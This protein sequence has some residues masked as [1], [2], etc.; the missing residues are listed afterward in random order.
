[1]SIRLP[2]EGKVIEVVNGSLKIPNEPIVAYIEG[3]GIGREVIPAA[4]KVVDKAV[5]TAYKGKRRIVWWKLL[6]GKEALQKVGKLLPEETVKGIAEVKVALKGPMETP[7]GTGHRSINVALRKMFDLYANIRPIKYYGVPTVYP[8]ADK[9][10]LIIFRENTEDVYAG[11]EWEAYSREAQKLREFLKNEFGIE[12]REDSGITL[13]PISK[14]ATQ[15]IVRKA[16]KWAIEKG[17]KRVTIMHKGNVMKFTEGAFR[18]WA[19]E[20]AEKEFS[21]YV[22]IGKPEE[23]KILVDDKIADNMLQQIILRPWEYDIIVTPNLNGDYLSDAA[24][25]LVGGVGMAAG[26]NVGDY[27]AIAEPVHGT[28]PDI[29]GKGIANP[30]A[31]ILSAALLLEYLGWV[32]AAE[33]IRASLR[34]T[35]EK[36][37][38]T[39]DLARGE[40]ALSTEEF[41]QEVIKEIEGE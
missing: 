15:R 41:I 39:P 32:E 10:D 11:I 21:E 29:A 20:V 8:Y 23:G 35:I 7:I 16:I 37:K 28:A 25:A 13:K 19:F 14:F 18:N 36:G 34:K 33:L 17:R 27:I 4:I 6:A 31:A 26:I 38:V 24:A 5:E 3:D 1:M 12:I 9:V 2:Q 22:S 40:K 30:S